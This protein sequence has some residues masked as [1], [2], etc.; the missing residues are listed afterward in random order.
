MSKKPT[1]VVAFPRGGIIPASVLNEDEDYTASPH[2]PVEVPKAYGDHLIADRLAYDVLEADKRKKAEN[3]AA[4][5]T[6]IAS[7]ADK[8]EVDRLNALTVSLTAE[9]DKLAVGLEAVAGKIA[10]LNADN[11]ELSDDLAKLQLS[12]KTATDTV[13]QLESDK[14]KLSGEVG[15]LQRD[16]DEAQL[17]LKT[18][19]ENV[20]TLTEQL[21]EATKPPVQQQETLNMDGANGKSK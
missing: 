14:V 18:E 12:L 21:S 13:A 9:R 11:I 20:V 1:I 10:Q 7:V 5:Q 4:A 16:L 3:E 17:L 8:G 6:V 2:K 19:R 15:E